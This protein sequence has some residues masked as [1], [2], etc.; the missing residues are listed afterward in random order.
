MAY[1]NPD[2]ATRSAVEVTNYQYVGD[3]PRV[4]GYIKTLFPGW[5]I[6][7]SNTGGSSTTYMSDYGYHANLPASGQVVRALLV[8]GD[9]SYGASA[10]LRYAFSYYS[11]SNTHAYFGARL[12]AIK[13]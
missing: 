3:I 9:A 12:R 7:K 5:S 8:S 13:L 10:G 1:I 6:V 4:D 2:W 11:P